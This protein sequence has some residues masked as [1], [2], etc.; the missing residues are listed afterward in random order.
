MANFADEL[1]NVLLIVYLSKS[2]NKEPVSWTSIP[3]FIDSKLTK[4]DISRKMF[5]PP[6]QR[7]PFQ[8]SKMKQSN[9]VINLEID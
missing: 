4:G 9:M 2:V 5:Q 6:F 8:G 3:I 7:P 1:E